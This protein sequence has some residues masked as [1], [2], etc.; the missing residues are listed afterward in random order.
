M[1]RQPVAEAVKWRLFLSQAATGDP[2][3]GVKSDGLKQYFQ[4]AASWDR[5]RMKSA[6]LSRNLA[7][8]VAA[9]AGGIAVCGVVAVAMLAPLKSVEPFVIRV[10][11]TTGAVDI[12]TALTGSDEITYNEAVSKYFIGQYVRAREGYNPAA[13]KENFDQVAVMSTPTLQTAW[14]TYYSRTNPDSPQNLY[15][16]SAAA[17]DIRAISF[18]NERVANVRYRLTVTTA[19]AAVAQD[20]I[21]TVTFGYSKAPL[22]ESDRLRNP[23]G[24]QVSA[25]RSD[26]EAV[27]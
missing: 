11:E 19:K 3:T 17:V 2:M 22:S 23:L 15:A 26:P 16:L 14:T 18:V 13:A 20:H 7:W 12:V 5:D 1:N 9:V 21:A 24:F 4:E 25:Y 27:L 6:L 10:N 8:T